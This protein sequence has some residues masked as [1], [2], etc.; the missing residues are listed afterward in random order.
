MEVVDKTI[1]MRD[2]EFPDKGNGGFFMTYR[3]FFFKEKEPT[4]TNTD[5]VTKVKK[6]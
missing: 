5:A 3:F 6:I 2:F 1:L 4:K